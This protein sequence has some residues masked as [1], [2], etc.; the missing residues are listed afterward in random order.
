M[1]PLVHKFTYACLI[2]CTVGQQSVPPRPTRDLPVGKHE[3]IAV[4]PLGAL[5]VGVEEAGK[6]RERARRFET[7]GRRTA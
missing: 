5:R 7:A 3:S 6:V 2:A 4:I 1:R